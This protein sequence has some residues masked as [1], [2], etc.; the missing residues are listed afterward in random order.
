MN[1]MFKNTIIFSCLLIDVSRKGCLIKSFIHY[2]TFYSEV[3]LI[4]TFMFP[5]YYLF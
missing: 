5:I 3:K 1:E 2:H 4:L